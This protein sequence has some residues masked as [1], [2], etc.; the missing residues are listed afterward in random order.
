[1]VFY[2]LLS[3]LEIAATTWLVD[4]DTACFFHSHC[5]VGLDVS[6]FPSVQ[7]GVRSDEL[8][9]L[10]IRNEASFSRN[11]S[12]LWLFQGFQGLHCFSWTFH[13]ELVEVSRFLPWIAMY[14]GHVGGFHWFQAHTQWMSV[15]VMGTTPGRRYGALNDAT[16][17][18][19]LMV[20]GCCWFD[21]TWLNSLA[22]FR[23]FLDV[24]IF[25]VLF[26]ICSTSLAFTPF[27]EVMW[28]IL[29]DEFPMWPHY[30]ISVIGP[31]FLSNVCSFSEQSIGE[32][33]P[34]S[35]PKPVLCYPYST[36]NPVRWTCFSKLQSI[37]W[38]QYDS[39][40]FHMM[41]SISQ[42]CTEKFFSGKVY[43]TSSFSNALQF[44]LGIFEQQK[45][46]RKPDH[47]MIKSSRLLAIGITWNRQV[48]PWSS[49]SPCWS[50]LVATMDSRWTLVAYWS[51]IEA[52]WS[53]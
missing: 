53:R 52:C 34:W 40:W 11:P 37:S 33:S 19:L 13:A 36:H 30:V 9:L 24:W 43:D 51:I 16:S 49:T 28:K 10:D 25:L 17:N 1:M 50:S 41:L 26:Y 12:K 8:Y 44:A 42:H 15:P 29:G 35:F 46:Q 3:L 18:W 20:V 22:L 23:I 27:A 5:L 47:T 7:R 14:I 32:F 45:T 6:T 2:F 39:I 38:T 4:V 31:R 21:W 48:T